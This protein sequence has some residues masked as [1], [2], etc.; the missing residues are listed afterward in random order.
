MHLF[1]LTSI[2]TVLLQS[3][4][5]MHRAMKNLRLPT[6]P[7]KIEQ[8]NTLTSCLSS[9][10]VNKYSSPDQFFLPLFPHFVLLESGV[11]V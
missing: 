11:A 6:F 8:G 4:T 2:L 10:T 7:A 9:P 5:G 1:N 3:F